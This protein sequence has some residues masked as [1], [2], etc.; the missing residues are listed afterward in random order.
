MSDQ[1]SYTTTS[2]EVAKIF[3]AVAVQR[4][5]YSLNALL[6]LLTVVTTLVAG[7]YLMM[8][9]EAT[10]PAS[11]HPFGFVLQILESPGLL[12]K[13]IAY[14][15]TIM[16]V[17]LAHEMG[18]YLACQYYGVQ[19]TL[20]F[21]IPAPVGVM[22]GTFGAFI[23]IKS[24][25]PNRRALFDVGLAGPIAGF[26]FLLPFLYLG[27]RWS[28]Q[29]PVSEVSGEAGYFGEPLI[30]RLFAYFMLK[31]G[32][33]TFLHPTGFAV[34]FACLATSLNLLPIAQLDGGHVSYAV[35]GRRAHVITWIFFFAIIG[36]GIYGFTQSWIAGF[37]W[38]FYAVVLLI[39]R[40][41]A[42]FKHPPTL[43]DSEPI[44]FARKIWAVIA[45][46]VFALTFVPVTIFLK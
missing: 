2:P 43:D 44:G 32:Y 28:T 19:A 40:Q 13:G 29:V 27:L 30:F 23:R 17:L 14:A 5:R 3:P 35:F 36:L 39:L 15:G 34:W 42:G 4:Q 16:L 25:F 33:V 21:F 22:T 31:D 24:P 20:P 45:L 11:I 1:Y 8:I 10:G 38:L 37:Q 9:H 12:Y 7:T 18:H 46:I 41:I 6:F 26:V